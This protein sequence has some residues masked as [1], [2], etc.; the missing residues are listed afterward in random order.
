[1]AQQQVIE[2]LRCA[3]D[4]VITGDPRTDAPVG[5]A[6]AG[7]RV[8]VRRL[9]WQARF[10]LV[11]PNEVVSNDDYHTALLEAAARVEEG[12]WP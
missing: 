10:Q 7:L 5:I 3:A 6:G 1:M 11:G 9:A 12:S 4:V 2:L 8:A